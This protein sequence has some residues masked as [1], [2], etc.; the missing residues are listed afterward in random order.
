MNGRP[1]MTHIKRNLAGTAAIVTIISALATATPANAC[2]IGKNCLIR[3]DAGRAADRLQKDVPILKVPEKTAKKT[4]EIIEDVGKGAIAIS[5]LKTLEDVIIEGKSLDT[6]LD[7]ALDDAKDLAR[8]VSRIPALS[9]PM[10]D[11]IAET[12][13]NLLGPDV[14]RGIGVLYLPKKI[15]NVLPE[16]LTE[17]VIAGTEHPKKADDVVG[18]PLAAAIRQAHDHY[19]DV[20]QPLPE[21]TRKLLKLGGM[22]DA[23][24]AKVRYVVDDGAGSIAGLINLLQTQLGSATDTNHAVAIDNIIVFAKEPAHGLG[25]LF[26]WAHEVHHTKQYADMGIEGFADNYTKDAAKIENEADEVATRT[27]KA[28]VDL[29]RSLA[30]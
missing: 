17:A 6:S 24:L 13:G 10:Y 19:K 11:A 27:V 22:D 1:Y 3:G 16:A 21:T 26:F 29:L 7:E 4:I 12:G 18:I 30:S 14:E 5:G 23:H 20:A 9:N 8:G 15:Q 25:D 2:L 28:V